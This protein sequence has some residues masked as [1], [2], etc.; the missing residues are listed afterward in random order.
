MYAR[1]RNRGVSPRVTAI[2][3][4]H[5]TSCLAQSSKPS[6]HFCAGKRKNSQ[7][8]SLQK[9]P[10]LTWSGHRCVAPHKV[11]A[12]SISRCATSP[13]LPLLRQMTLFPSCKFE[14]QTNRPGLHIAGQRMGNCVNMYASSPRNRR[15]TSKAAT[16]ELLCTRRVLVVA[17]T[18]IFPA[19][20]KKLA[21]DKLLHFFLHFCD[22]TCTEKEIRHASGHQ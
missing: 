16:P 18:T 19:R 21:T 17:V 8:R 14:R 13:A 12:P 22:A 1:C 5:Y 7:K 11:T 4:F 9:R 20:A 6:N 10:S 2:D 3:D 15:P